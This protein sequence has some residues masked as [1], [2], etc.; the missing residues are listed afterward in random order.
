[1]S[2]EVFPLSFHASCSPC[3]T[4][5]SSSSLSINSLGLP[6]LTAFHLPSF[7]HLLPELLMCQSPSLQHLLNCSLELLFKFLH[8][9]LVSF[10]LRLF[11]QC[12]PTPGMMDSLICQ[13][14][15]QGTGPELRASLSKVTRAWSLNFFF[16]LHS[17]TFL[18]VSRVN[19]WSQVNKQMG[20]LPC[21]PIGFLQRFFKKQAQEV[22]N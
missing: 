3:L 5:C 1:M 18:V 21:S 2:D 8:V 17:E 13:A 19:T 7:Q 4:C 12:L 15:S 14:F 22:A 20:G 9:C 16:L 11:A 6:S 10:M